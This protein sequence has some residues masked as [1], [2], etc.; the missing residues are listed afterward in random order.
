MRGTS[1]GNV[2]TGLELAE[3][4]ALEADGSVGQ[5]V[6]FLVIQGLLSG[7]GLASLTLGQQRTAKEFKSEN[8]ISLGATRRPVGTMPGALPLSFV[9]LFGTLTRGSALCS[10]PLHGEP[11]PIPQ[12]GFPS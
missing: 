2:V 8:T 7:H 9:L 11:L 5:C 12:W 6:C 4:L 1:Y 10:G 3:R